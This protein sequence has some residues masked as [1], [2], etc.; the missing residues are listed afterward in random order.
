MVSTPLIAMK[1]RLDMG[2]AYGHER[3]VQSPT[4]ITYKSRPKLQDY[5]RQPHAK[6]PTTPQLNAC[7]SL[8]MCQQALDT[9]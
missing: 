2:L 7:M 6:R 1:K 4:Q 9:A 3:A 5:A 8:R